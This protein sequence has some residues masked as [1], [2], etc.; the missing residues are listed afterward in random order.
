[1]PARP[2]EVGELVITDLHNYGMPFVRYKVGDLAVPADRACSCGRGL[3]L[4]EDIEGRILDMIWTPDGRMVPGEFFPHLMKEFREVRQF[5]VVQEA[6]DRLIIRIVL[7]ESLADERLAFI[8]QQVQEVLGG[9]IRLDFEFP[10]EIPLTASG[11]FRVTVSAVR[12]AGGSWQQ[13]D[14]S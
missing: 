1:V 11:K 9:A 13:A 7:A 5:Q 12:N 14:G 6:L 4:L 10:E 3:P 2:G 8:R